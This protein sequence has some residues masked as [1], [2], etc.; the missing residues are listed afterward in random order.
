MAQGSFKQVFLD[1][2]APMLPAAA[3]W[4]CS[5]FSNGDKVDLGGTIVAVTG[6]RA[7]RRLLEL[8]VASVTG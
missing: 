3:R 1:W 7:G 6:R 8:I 2:H 5:T 4:L